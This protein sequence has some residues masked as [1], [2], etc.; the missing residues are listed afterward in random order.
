MMLFCS[1][2]TV[3]NSWLFCLFSNNIQTGWS[4]CILCTL[5]F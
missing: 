2:I 3:H 5:F 1:S 4:V